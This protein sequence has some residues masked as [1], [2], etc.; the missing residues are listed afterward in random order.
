MAGVV[1][2]ESAVRGVVLKEDYTVSASKQ[3]NLVHLVIIDIK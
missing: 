2:K 3:I 1:K